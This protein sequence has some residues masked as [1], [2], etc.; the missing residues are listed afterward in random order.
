MKISINKYVPELSPVLEYGFVGTRFGELLAA[1]TAQGL[2]VV[3]FVDDRTESLQRLQQEWSDCSTLY[4]VDFSD[5]LDQ[6]LEPQADNSDTVF[7]LCL[8]G[9]EFQMDVWRA[10]LEIP[11]G[12]TAT[13]SDVARLAGHSRAVRAAASA[14]GSNRVSLIVP[15]HRVIRKS[16]AMGGY[17]WGIDRKIAL[18]K[19]ERERSETTAANKCQ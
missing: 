7:E 1:R 5:Y 4:S 3:E 17:R 10:L 11:F 6:W 9:S 18:L 12:K 8:R 19:W 13:Y 16:G 2:C 14:V 15:C